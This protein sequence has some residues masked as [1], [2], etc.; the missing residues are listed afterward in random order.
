MKQSKFS[1][2][3]VVSM[4]TALSF[5]FVCFLGKNFSTMGNTLVSITWGVIIAVLLGG[6]AY[7]AKSLK[8]TSQ[9][10]K[11]NFIV[12]I[13]VLFL[14]T[15]L[16]I[17]FSYSPFPHFLNV[18]KQ[19]EQIE[20]KIQKS[21]IQ[22]ENMFVKY[23]EYAQTKENSY[24]GKLQSVVFA[25]DIRPSDYSK[26]GFVQGGPSDDIQIQTKVETLDILLFPHHY[27]D[28]ISKKGIKDIAHTWL[29]KA[30]SITNNWKPIGI[31]N[32]INMIENNS[33]DWRSQLINLS[34]EPVEGFRYEE[35]D[36]ELTFDQVKTY[37]ISFNMPSTLSICISIG[38]YLLMLLSYFISSR[39][40][41]TTIFINKV[42]GDY[43]INY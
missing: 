43:D 31:V 20:R 12:E 22:A 3:D 34:K 14:F 39:S 4:L 21:I 38:A 42:K 11:T 16:M 25:K 18:T 19:K 27:R 2:A 15:G 6:T 30:K 13:I 37:F 32:V 7:I 33:L 36:Y 10:F 40:T 23:E 1:L 28:T 24:R 8:C 26:F 35:F 9:N 29:N 17:F 5:G 41:K